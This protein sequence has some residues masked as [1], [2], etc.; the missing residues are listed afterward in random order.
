LAIFSPDRADSY[1]W[2]DR[3]LNRLNKFYVWDVIDARDIC[4]PYVMY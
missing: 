3:I 1:S 2:T 4:M